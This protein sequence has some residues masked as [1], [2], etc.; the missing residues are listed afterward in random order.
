MLRRRRSCQTWS[1]RNFRRATVAQ[2]SNLHMICSMV[3]WV[4]AKKQLTLL[5]STLE[6]STL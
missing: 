1:S 4:H 2:S 6:V 5:G 3:G